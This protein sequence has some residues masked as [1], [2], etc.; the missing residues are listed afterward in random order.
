MTRTITPALVALALAASPA[1]A[2][3]ADVR[4]AAG[5]W[6]VA[7]EDVLRVRLENTKV[8]GAPA[9]RA[10][11]TLAAP[12]DPAAAYFVHLGAGCMTWTLGTRGG[13]E[14]PFLAEYGCDTPVRMPTMLP[15]TAAVSGNDVVLTAPLAGHLRRGTVV[16]HLAAQSAPAMSVTVHHPDATVTNGDYAAGSV[17]HAV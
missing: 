9:V 13:A 4:D 15:A 11:V 5:D 10:V 7:S 2:A 1:T 6:P 16:A 3:P 8:D 17:R 14:G 12:T